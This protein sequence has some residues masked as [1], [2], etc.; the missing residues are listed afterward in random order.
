MNGGDAA[1]FRDPVRTLAHSTLLEGVRNRDRSALEKLYFEY[2]PY[3]TRFLARCAIRRDIAANIIVDVFAA[4]WSQAE[5]LPHESHAFTS[6]FGLAYRA[7]MRALPSESG[8]TTS[9]LHGE[10]RV[11]V[12]D[13]LDCNAWHRS[14]GPLPMEQRATLLLAYQI[15][16]SVEEIGQI[17][18]TTPQTVHSR[19]FFARECLREYALAM[20]PEALRPAS[21]ITER[22]GDEAGRD[23]VRASTNS[24]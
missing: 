11:P 12:T 2:H 18:R 17:A 7:A 6:I 13:T 4:L 8:M 14:L 16:C 9:R 20:D 21:R 19:M 10:R 24:E 3:L 23:V 22:D 5:Y 1:P 15:G